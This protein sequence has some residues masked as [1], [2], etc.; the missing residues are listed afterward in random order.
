[1]ASR[2][3]QQ[4]PATYVKVAEAQ[5]A[6]ANSKKVTSTTKA[7]WETRGPLCF[8]LIHG[9]GSTFVRDRRYRCLMTS[10]EL[11]KAK[12][13]Q[14]WVAEK[15]PTGLTP[16]SIY[17]GQDP[18]QMS[19][20]V[21]I[22]I[23]NSAPSR[24]AL[25]KLHKSRIGNKAY[26]LVVVALSETHA[27]LF[28]PSSMGGVT[29][30]L[31]RGQALRLLQSALDEPNSIAAT[32]R[33]AQIQ[34]NVSSSSK[35]GITNSGLFASHHLNNNVPMQAHWLDACAK[36][37]EIIN[38]SGL[39]LINALGFTT[40]RATADAVVLT[41]GSPNPRAVAVLLDEA[42]HFDAASP[43]YQLSPVAYGLKVATEQDVP[44]LIL[45]RGGQIRLYPAKDGVG[46]GQ[47][48][49]ADTFFELDL[50]LLADDD[51]GLLEVIFS[52]SALAPGGSTEQVLNDSAKYATELGSRLKNR[53]YENVIPELS[54]AVAGQLPNIGVKVDAEGLNLAYRLTL[55][56]LFRLLF[57]AYAEDRGL[58]PYDRNERYTNNALKTLIIRDLIPN[59]ENEFDA[60]S[61]TLWDDLTQVWH[62]IDG[63]AKSW[64]VPA[65]NGGLFGEEEDLHPEGYLI[66][67]MTMH[68][69]AMGP[70]LKHM[71]VDVSGEG[72]QGPV[73]FRSLS[74]REF[75]TIYE[76]LLES[77]LS[78]ADQD[79]TVDSKGA[80][81]PASKDDQVLAAKGEVYF[82][83]SSGE[84]KA[85]GSYFTPSIIVDH[86]LDRALDP[87]LE[88][89]FVRVKAELDAGNEVRA[90]EI[91]FDFR[92]ADLAM[93][94]GHF[95]VSAVDRIESAMRNFLVE[96]NV[97][98]VS[99]E[100]QRLEAA[101][102]DA[103]GDDYQF[104]GDIDKAGLLRRQIAR[105]CIYGLDINPLAVELS[106]LALWIHTFV[107]G[108]P[109]SSL[110]HGLVCA[111][112]L[113]GIGTIDEA[114]EALEPNSTGGQI[115]IFEG[116][117]SGA[118]DKAKNLL[119]D[120][121]NADEA[122]KQ[123]VKDAAKIA[124]Q[125]RKAAE[126]TKHLFDAAV[127]ARLGEINAGSFVDPDQ[128]REMGASDK[129]QE[130]VKPLNPAHM[131]YL[132]PEVFL[133]G[134][135]G[136]D[137]LLGN[138]PWEEL[139]LEE[140]RFWLARQPGLFGMTTKKMHERVLELRKE[141][142]QDY[143][144]FKIEALNVEVTRK[145]L[146]SGPFP[147]IGTGDIDLYQAFSWRNWD[148]TRN[149]GALGLVLPR[150]VLSGAS[151]A[152]WRR[153][154][155]RN[156]DSSI[157]TLSNN[158]GWVF[159]GV[160]GRY[161]IALITAQKSEE[162]VGLIQLGGPF[163]DAISFLDGSKELGR[164]SFKQ[165]DE[166]S[167]SCSVPQ[168]PS[169][170][171]VVVFGKLRES[172]RF[173]SSEISSAFRY[174]REFDATLDRK[175]FSTSSQES[176]IP[177][178]AG[179]GFNLW[180]PET[181]EVFSYAD[182]ELAITQL[183]N[184]RKNQSK[185]KSSAFFGME[186]ALVDD[187]E[188]LDFF[189]PRIALRLITNATNT[190]TLIASLVPPNTFLTN[191]APYLNNKTKNAINEAYILGVL[192][193]IPLDWFAR[194][195][196]ELNVNAHIFNGFPIPDINSHKLWRDRIVLDSAR[197]AAVDERYSKWAKEI[198][199]AVGSVTDEATKDDLISELDALVSLMYGLNEPQV[200]HI[201]QTFHRGWDYKPRLESVLKHFHAWKDK[202]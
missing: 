10:S 79:L 22:A 124:K 5:A 184:K 180:T 28:G 95:L 197:L 35:L 60:E 99:R 64:N 53:I 129:V 105:R 86:L 161:S 102:K 36:S 152:Q 119:V 137:V 40:K 85:T 54:K 41:G 7:S 120:A 18:N 61:Q 110:D 195:Y 158:Q 115:S 202:K 131:P 167:S 148:L 6:A 114:L 166:S 149:S 162:N 100:L 20:E 48:G 153:S 127:A 13:H 76:G 34:V 193:S 26:P 188:T 71:F 126:S 15:P 55:R 84:R 130:L 97:P 157:V 176:G 51:A 73:D 57:Q 165:I 67:Q 182:Q 83:S 45:L 33:I 42:E 173:D 138:P 91:F 37:R 59:T 39:D 186:K 159:E 106:R 170:E 3:A 128:V 14:T 80:W 58:L 81:V 70:A 123:E 132:F 136:F 49:Q 111:N 25:A 89:H 88:Q 160:D 50:A 168:L 98:G 8:L 118:L 11:F 24:E 90:H 194:R 12:S 46:V 29:G 38:K 189:R 134:N 196:V 19:L 104:A 200:I 135:P 108:L 31:D 117:I 52:A 171:S 109:M 187:V 82:H 96:N 151:G 139:K 144:N 1:M 174:V 63:G 87:A 32:Q 30:P 183:F 185:L 133:R 198:G 190:R 66:K 2:C 74:V 92:V 143:L 179:S 192:C 199:V 43:K 125:A 62:A 94:S 44:W 103:L 21:A 47:R 178:I 145:A 154:V 164:L 141:R 181:G 155:L 93:G 156:S 175:Y 69:S 169:A 172:P 112:S 163:F 9:S 116:A 16:N 150:S 56:I 147:G 75:G 4:A 72:V 68:D 78:L 101:A 177:V 140:H 142:P 17:V 191:A 27:W 77:S 121:A 65:Y 107:P 122:N 201:F 146:L 113:T 23:T